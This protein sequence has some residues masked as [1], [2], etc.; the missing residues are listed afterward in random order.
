[1]RIVCVG[2]GPAGLYVAMLMKLR[3]PDYRSPLSSATRPA[4][5]TAGV[6]S[7]GTTCS[8]TAVS[9]RPGQRPGGG[10]GGAS[11]GKAS[12][13]GYPE[14]ESAH[15]GGYG[16]SIG[17]AGLLD[18]LA[19][20]AAELGVELRYESRPTHHRSRRRPGRGRPT[21]PT[22]RSGD[23]C[24]PRLRHDDRDRAQQVSLAW[25]PQGLRH[26]HLRVRA[27]R[28]GLD[29]VPRLPL[30]ERHEHLHRRVPARDLVGSRVRR[31][32]TAR[33]APPGCRRSSR[34]ISTATDSSPAPGAGRSLTLAELPPDHQRDLAQP[35]RRAHRRRRPHH[36]LLGRR[37]DPAG[38]AG[39][40]RTR[41]PTHHA[42]RRP[43]TPRSPH[44]TRAAGLPCAHAK[45]RPETA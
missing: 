26:V 24:A 43:P 31:S 34:R 21:E 38:D 16:F 25:H 4:P 3:H 12:G 39:R 1:M 37:G 22:A 20:R 29:L 41:R 9:Q 7:S 13:S 18:I 40:R 30:R 36:T 27:D 11:C 33:H 8:T 28:G 42:R 44:T 10:A 5:P 15:L 19:A 45:Q 17:R 32:H 14:G 2:G 23:G 35:Q 6:S